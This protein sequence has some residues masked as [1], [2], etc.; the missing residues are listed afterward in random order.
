MKILVEMSNNSQGVLARKPEILDMDTMT[1]LVNPIKKQVFAA[2]AALRLAM[3]NADPDCVAQIDHQDTLDP[4]LKLLEEDDKD[5]TPTCRSLIHHMQTPLSAE[6]VTSLR[7]M[8]EEK[9]VKLGAFLLSVGFCAN[10]NY[11]RHLSAL[12]E[13]NVCFYNKGTKSIVCLWNGY[14]VEEIRELIDLC[15]ALE[16]STCQQP[17]ATPNSTKFKYKLSPI[18]LKSATCFV[19]L[20]GPMI[21]Y[22][23]EDGNGMSS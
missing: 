21:G 8:A 15:P 17:A 11:C 7:S 1:S 19:N 20:V 3:E 18:S 10:R 13:C 14:S 22:G 2:R 9:P 23:E 16:K 4:N 6:V 5:I 12:R